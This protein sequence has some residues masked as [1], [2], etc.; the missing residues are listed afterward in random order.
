MF[1]SKWKIKE[2]LRKAQL[3]YEI[4]DG[5]FRLVVDV[6]EDRSQLVFINSQTKE[7]GGE[8]IVE[9]WSPAYTETPNQQ[10]RLALHLLIAS[11]NKE[12]GAWQAYLSDAQ[13]TFIFVAKV[14]LSALT[15]SFLEAICE[16][17]AIIA[18]EVEERLTGEDEF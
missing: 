1:S 4:E 16:Y 6:G 9:I 17:V 7:I 10:E 3:E 8:E 15:P 14:P 18:D 13:V 11:E 5:I 12:I 2:L